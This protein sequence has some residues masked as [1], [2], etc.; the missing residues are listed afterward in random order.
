MST[1]QL[2]IVC[3]R[4]VWEHSGARIRSIVPAADFAILEPDARFSTPDGQT[5]DIA[6][7]DHVFLSEDLYRATRATV[8]AS[9]QVA[10]SGVDWVH[11][12]SAGIDHPMFAAMLE[13]GATLS[14]APGQHSTPMAEY[15]IAQIL[16]HAKRM[17]AH[18][19]AQREH[20]WRPVDSE[21]LTGRTIGIVGYGAIGAAIAKLAHAFDMRVV[22]TKR[23][24]VE[25]PYLDEWLTPD[26][27]PDLLAQADYVVVSLPLTDETRGLIDAPQLAQMKPSALLMNVAR[28]GIVVEQALV[29]ALSEGRLAAAVLDVTEREPLPSDSPLWDVPNLVITPHDSGDSALGFTRTVDHWLRNLARYA[30]GQP[31]QDIAT[32]TGLSEDSARR[33][34]LGQS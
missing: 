8:A 21:E 34:E 3:T 11:S 14:H 23:N 16:C 19:D 25:D 29:A 4:E 28:G 27:L 33:R 26:R 24:G 22:A 31:L 32:T 20:A 12:S 13:S 1:N 17:E 5:A 10:T 7:V 18:A 6:S 15:V 9:V 30:R 2:K